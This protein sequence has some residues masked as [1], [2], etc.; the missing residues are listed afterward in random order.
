MHTIEVRLSDDLLKRLDERV[1]ARG[2]DRSDYIGEL[3]EKELNGAPHAGMT[4]AELLTLASGRSPADEMT[5]EELA[6]FAVEEVRAHRAEKRLRA[7]SG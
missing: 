7:K 5:D 4:F 1:R 3:L 2:V 6:Q